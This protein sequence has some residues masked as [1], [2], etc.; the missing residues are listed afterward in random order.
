VNFNEVSASAWQKVKDAYGRVNEQ[1]L[2]SLHRSHRWLIASFVLILMAVLVL[3][4]L[5][6]SPTGPT[7]IIIVTPAPIV[8]PTPT[9]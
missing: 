4:L 9:P 7:Q 2:R 8:R 1:K 6:A 3:V 5:P